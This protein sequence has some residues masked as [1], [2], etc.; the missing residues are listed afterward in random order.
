MATCGD[1]AGGGGD[2][3]G[4]GSG[5]FGG[6]GAFG[7]GRQVFRAYSSRRLT[8]LL[9]LGVAGDDSS[10]G[11]WLVAA[12]SSAG[13]GVWRTALLVFKFQTIDLLHHIR[14]HIDLVAC[15]TIAS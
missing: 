3:D 11:L 9:R 13:E 15:H 12:S 2:P 6:A 14:D 7:G 5:V 4:C 8:G 1:A 10:T